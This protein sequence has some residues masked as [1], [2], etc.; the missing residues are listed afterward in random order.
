MPE[1]PAE[2][3]EPELCLVSEIKTEPDAVSVTEKPPA[4]SK[5]IDDTLDAEF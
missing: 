5:V 4:V 2:P 1:V 3:A